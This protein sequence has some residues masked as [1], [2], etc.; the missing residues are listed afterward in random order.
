MS[1]S[2]TALPT[3]VMTD[4]PGRSDLPP[5][6]EM[7]ESILV[8]ISGAVPAGPMLPGFLLTVPALILFAVVLLAPLV[9]VAALVTLA[10]AI[11]AIPYLLFRSIRSIRSRRAARGGAE[12]PAV[13]DMSSP[14][15]AA[16][17]RIVG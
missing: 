16:A 11:L 12:R 13:G 7:V 3:S 9:L 1:S 2:S 4:A 15:A 8:L 10:G 17:S 5:A 6:L 14:R